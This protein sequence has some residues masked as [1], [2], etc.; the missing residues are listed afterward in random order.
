MGRGV[1]EQDLV[2]TEARVGQHGA[3]VDARIPGSGSAPARPQMVRARSTWLV[4]AD[5][6]APAVVA[7]ALTTAGTF[8]I[9][10]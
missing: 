6:V 10:S 2:P 3:E 7:G 5:V 1:A 4:S 9:S 8:M